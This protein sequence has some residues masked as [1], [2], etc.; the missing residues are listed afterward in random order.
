MEYT[1]FDVS[2]TALRPGF[3]ALVTMYMYGVLDRLGRE[4]FAYHWH[5]TGVSAIGSPHFH[6]STTPPV[7][8]PSQPGTPRATELVLSRIHFP[9]HRIELPELVRFLIVELGVRPRRQDWAAVLDR[10]EQTSR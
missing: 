7:L 1:V 3:E 5:P 6:A 10:I 8:L 2:D 4:L 9:T